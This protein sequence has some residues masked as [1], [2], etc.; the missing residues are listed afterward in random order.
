MCKVHV[1]DANMTRVGIYITEVF[2][3]FTEKNSDII[4]MS[5]LKL[6]VSYS[7]LAL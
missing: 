4:C 1:A 6:A 3:F 7:I 2:F 5:V